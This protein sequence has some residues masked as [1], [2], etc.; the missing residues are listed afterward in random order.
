MVKYFKRYDFSHLSVSLILAVAALC[1]IGCYC[2]FKSDG[3]GLAKRQ[4]MGIIAGLFI[5]AFVILVDYHFI[6]RFAIP[7]YGFAV[8][9]L[10]LT[11]FSPL[12]ADHSTGKFRWLDIGP[13]EIQPSE[14][15][16]IIMIIVMAVFFTRYR[17]KLNKWYMF[18]ISVAIVAVPTFLILIQTDLSSSMVCMFVFIVMIFMAG[19]SWKII[20][21]LCAVGVPLSI[22]L[23]WYI[24]QPYQKL[25]TVEQQGRVLSFLNPAESATEG[26]YQ[27]LKSVQAIAA[28]GVIGKTL[29][30]DNTSARQYN[31]V[32]VNESD[33]IFSV[34]GEELG[35][36]GCVLVIAL[37]AFI[38]FKCVII[39]RKAKDLTGRLIAYGVSGMLM[40]QSFVNIAVATLLIPNTGLPLP[41]LS[42]GLTSLLSSIIAVSLVI[43]VGLQTGTRRG[44][45]FNQGM[46]EDLDMDQI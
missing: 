18:F 4:L 1:S 22:F 3:T 46:S 43:N 27:Q 38:V 24:Q 16:K 5:M 10:I 37:F 20:G 25:L 39:A 15:V 40:F 31:Y 33:F 23:F 8:V 28:G 35:F 44:L 32:Y 14:L 42:Y 30:G 26:A 29:L 34:I 19:L 6:C 13:T 41:F 9:I 36:F 21:T 17:K 2:I 45:S 12:G 7:L 11:R